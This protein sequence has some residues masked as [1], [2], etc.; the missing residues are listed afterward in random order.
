M[1][2][3][4]LFMGAA[5]LAA[6]GTLQAQP[7]NCYGGA[8]TYVETGTGKTVY[9]MSN[10]GTCNPP[11]LVATAAWATNT[12]NF[13]RSFTLDYDAKFTLIKGHGA[14]DGIV[15]VFGSY[16][17]YPNPG[18]MNQGGGYLGY[19]D[20]STV[21]INMDFQNSYA[22]E[23]DVYN[24]NTTISTSEPS[25]YVDHVMIS[26]NASINY[27]GTAGPVQMDPLFANVKNGV[28][29]HMQITWD[30]R[31]QTLSVFC[32]GSLRLSQY[33]D[34]SLFTDPFHVHWGFTAGTGDECLVQEIRDPQIILGDDCTTGGM[35]SPCAVFTDFAGTYFRPYPPNPLRCE[36]NATVSVSATPGWQICG[37]SWTTT[38]S[39]TPTPIPGAYPTASVTALPFSFNSAAGLEEVFIE[40][41]LCPTGGGTEHCHFGIRKRVN[42]NGGLTGSMYRQS[43]TSVANAQ[44]DKDNKITLYPNPVTDQLKVECPDNVLGATYIVKDM[45]GKQ[46]LKGTIHAAKQ[47]IPT[48]A[49]AE[50]VYMLE[51]QKQGVTIQNIRF[52]RQ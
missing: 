1:K 17:D 41:D 30:C 29:R 19:Y 6:A 35:G 45:T 11:T 5:M 23:M 39:T 22:V 37:L 24:N 20:D 43:S 36:F 28:Y 9:Q 10:S 3:K 21:G 34:V 50:G 8:L 12:L 2:K 33:L 42:C 7:L 26:R 52:T 4:L 47:T 25:P 16:V 13:Y 18:S 38:S 14:A 15:A 31:T 51:V 40:A 48:A 27:G 44:N 49:L 46:L 32:N